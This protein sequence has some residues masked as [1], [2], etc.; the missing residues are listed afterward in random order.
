MYLTN[1]VPTVGR[2]GGSG[3]LQIRL[4]EGAL[5]ETENQRIVVD[6]NKLN[7]R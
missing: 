4:G 1:Q 5:N 3:N 2:V 7:G 6:G